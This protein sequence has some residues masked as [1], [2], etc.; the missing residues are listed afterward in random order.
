MVVDTLSCSAGDPST[1]P[2]VK[3]D[4]EASELADAKQDEEAFL[5]ELG[6]GAGIAEFLQSCSGA[7]VSNHVTNPNPHPNTNPSF[8][9]NPSPNPNWR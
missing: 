9:P 6:A 4:S 7:E 8:N 1:N 2:T 3:F 5:F